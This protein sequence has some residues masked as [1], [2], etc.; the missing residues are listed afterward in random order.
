MSKRVLDPDAARKG[1]AGALRGLAVGQHLLDDRGNVGIVFDDGPNFDQ[2]DKR[3]GKVAG[4][5]DGAR[6]ELP[7]A[8]QVGGMGEGGRVVGGGGDD[9]PVL[10]I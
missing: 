1:L 8:G 2:D 10:G 9:G 6:Q 5:P 3:H 7:R 4:A